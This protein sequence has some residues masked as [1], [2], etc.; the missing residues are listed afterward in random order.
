MT[1][2]LRGWTGIDK[3]SS[4][5]GRWALITNVIH[6]EKKSVKVAQKIAGYVSPSTTLIDEQPPEEMIGEALKGLGLLFPFNVR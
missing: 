6:K 5:S 1:V 3:A 2:M 4:L